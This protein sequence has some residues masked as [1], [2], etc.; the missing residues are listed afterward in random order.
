[1]A[2]KHRRRPRVTGENGETTTAAAGPGRGAQGGKTGFKRSRASGRSWRSPIMW[3][4]IAVV[5]AISGVVLLCG[6]P[7]GEMME[8]LASHQE[9]LQHK[10]YP[11]PC[12][13]DY[14]NHKQFTGC[15]PV[16]C[17]RAVTDAVITQEEAKRMLRIAE[18]GLSLGGSDGGASILDLHSGAL[19]MGKNFV[20]MYRYYGE[21]MKEILTENDFQMYRNVRRR[22]QQEIARTFDLDASSLHLTKPTFFSRMNSSEA[23]TAHDEYW[24]PHIDKVT[25]GSFDYTSLLYLSDYSRDFGGGRFIFIDKKTNS[26]VEPRLGP[27][28]HT[29]CGSSDLISWNFIVMADT[30][31]IDPRFFRQ[32]YTD[33]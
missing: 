28:E 8:V 5:L 13:Q 22:I 1:M 24:H 2:T 19:S 14:G 27:W 23:K 9:S 11:V 12:S 32:A 31:H 21:Q 20:N 29:L 4:V 7:S 17:G 6:Y 15:T 30:L 3:G 16:K 25:Y 18:S 26:T 33:D 10:F